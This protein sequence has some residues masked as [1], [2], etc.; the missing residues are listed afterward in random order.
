MRHVH[1]IDNT[2]TV[3]VGGSNYLR[4]K[5]HIPLPDDSFKANVFILSIHPITGKEEHIYIEGNSNYIEKA[6]Q[7]IIDQI[8]LCRKLNWENIK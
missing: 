6:C 3:S 4:P 7:E 2:C 1:D 8:K 5:D